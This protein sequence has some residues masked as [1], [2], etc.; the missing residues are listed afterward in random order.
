MI[1]E[2]LKLVSINGVGN[3]MAIFFGVQLF[4]TPTRG[5]GAVVVQRQDVTGLA[6]GGGLRPTDIA[7]ATFTISNLGMYGV[8]AFS[9]II[10]PPQ[11]AILAVGS[12]ADRVAPIAAQAQHPPDADRNAVLRPPGRRWRGLR[13]F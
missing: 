12:I 10:T 5:G 7:G 13:A 2:R 1:L 3:R 9:S 8:D 4:L 6:P 11:A